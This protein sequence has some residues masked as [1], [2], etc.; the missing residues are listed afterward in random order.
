MTGDPTI[1]SLPIVPTSTPKPSSIVSTRSDAIDGEIDLLNRARGFV[2]DLLI[3]QF[4]LC[5]M[6][7]QS[8]VSSADRS[9]SKRFVL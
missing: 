9:V 2:E 4:A 6:R 5:Q 7:S 1:P 8:I 3:F